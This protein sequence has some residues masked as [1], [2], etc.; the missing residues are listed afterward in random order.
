[1]PTKHLLGAIL[2]QPNSPEAKM[3]TV[4]VMYEMRPKVGFGNVQPRN[5]LGSLSNVP[6]VVPGPP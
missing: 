1:M 2:L 3:S 4:I 5:E 6:E